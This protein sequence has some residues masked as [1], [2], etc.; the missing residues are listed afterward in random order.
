MGLSAWRGRKDGG[1]LFGILRAGMR[2][3]S[4]FG[5][6]LSDWFEEYFPDAFV[7]AVLAVAVVFA[8]SL[9]LGNGPA[10]TAQWFGA[11]FWDLVKFTMQMVMIIITGYAV[12]VSPPVHRVIERLAAVPK[13]GPGAVAFVAV[14]SMLSSLFSWSFSLIF[15][16]LLAREVGRRV[17]A[18]DYRAIGAAAYLGL[19][20]IWALGLSS[21]AALIMASPGSL[22]ES[23]AKISGV[24]PLSATLLLWQSLAMAGILLAVSAGLAYL[25]APA[26]EDARSMD[27][28]SEGPPA[29][30]DGP[31][32]PGELLE[33]SPLLT[34]VLVGIGAAYLAQVVRAKGAGELLELNNYIFLFLL[35]GLLLHWRPRSFTKAVAGAVPAASGIL[36]QYPLYAGILKVM[37]ESGMAK[38]LALLFVSVSSHGTYPLLVGVYSAL[39]GVFIP[40]A[41]GKWLIEAPYLLEA[42]KPLGVH[43]GW[44]VQI[45]NAAEALPNLI[46]PFW[47]LPLLGI[48]RLKPRDIVGYSALQFIVH[49]PLVLFLVWAFNLTLAPL[50]VR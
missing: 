11:G 38:K 1:T 47:M 7:F 41:G 44:V 43:L 45:Y 19:G 23:L 31:L 25:S 50:P 24:I 9:A 5:I 12:A 26:P 6:A 8:G 34:L 10:Q 32:R 13:T 16:G 18:A 22:P 48:L 35:L 15:S 28:G 4:A 40:S 30:D 29:Q 39:L 36:V 42:A 33:H 21:S 49:V 46:H 20:S 17:R 2:S 3:L 14:F 37:T 27:L